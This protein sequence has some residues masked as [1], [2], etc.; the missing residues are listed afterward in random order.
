M[1]TPTNYPTPHV[2]SGCVHTEQEETLLAFSEWLDQPAIRDSPDSLSH[3]DLVLMYL[4]D[5]EP[6]VADESPV[7][8]ARLAED[9]Q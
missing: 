5:W 9:R 3:T 8:C 4:A 2:C 6:A 1:N 7:K